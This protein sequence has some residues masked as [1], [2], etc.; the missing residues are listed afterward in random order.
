[1]NPEYITSA[2]D[3]SRSNSVGFIRDPRR[4]EDFDRTMTTLAQSTMELTDADDI[5]WDALLHDPF[6]DFIDIEAQNP[7]N[8]EDDASWSAPS[9]GS[10]SCSVTSQSPPLEDVDAK[11]DPSSTSARIRTRS[12]TSS[13]IGS[14]TT[15]KNVCAKIKRK[16]K[17]HPRLSRP[18][19]SKTA[20]RERR[21]ARN[22]ELA[23]ESRLR[24]KIELQQLK[25]ENDQLKKKCTWLESLL[26]LATT[27]L[28]ACAMVAAHASSSGALDAASQAVA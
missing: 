5:M 16:G 12:S 11:K 4:G 21:M 14:T 1:M 7:L 20:K 9:V 3:L 27:L 13:S 24:R 18:D 28:M 8:D 17:A 10:E 25:E 6:D 22:R 23:A 19:E 15:T 2:R 26:P